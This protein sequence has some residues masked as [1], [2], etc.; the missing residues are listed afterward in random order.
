MGWRWVWVM[1]TALLLLGGS[2][3]FAAEMG[4]AD[5]S[6]IRWVEPEEPRLPNHFVKTAGHSVIV[7]GGPQSGAWLDRLSR[8]GDDSVRRLADLLDLPMGTQYHVVLVEDMEQFRTLQPAP[9]PPWAD[10]TAWPQ[11]G[12]I[13]LRQPNLRGG[14]ARPLTQ[15]LDHELVHVLLGRAFAPRSA[16]RWLQEGVAQVFAKEV[17]ADLTARIAKGSVTRGLFTLEE[18]S[19]GFPRDA[20]AAEQAYAQSADFILWLQQEHGERALRTLIASLGRGESIERASR[21]ATGLPLAELDKRWRSRLQQGVFSRAF[22]D[23]LDAWLL[24]LAGA[25]A[26]MLGVPRLWTRRRR[27]AAWRAEASA[28]DQL[29]RDVVRQRPDLSR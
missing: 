14:T 7:H 3:S 10:G 2:S 26:L 19:A 11:Q 8:H 15:V 9:P 24:G 22:G 18:L 1:V 13:F 25:L 16:P 29:A 23:D 27:F 28:I 6:E 12:L 4:P 17:G 21:A 20:L 5:P